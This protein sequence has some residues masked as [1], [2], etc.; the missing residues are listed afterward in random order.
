MV[1]AFQLFSTGHTT[2]LTEYYGRSDLGLH[3]KNL[4]RTAAFPAEALGVAGVWPHLGLRSKLPPSWSS[5]VLPGLSIV[6]CAA[7]VAGLIGMRA[8]SRRRGETDELV[9]RYLW[10]TVLLVSVLTVGTLSLLSL[11]VPLQTM[12]GHRDGHWTY[13]EELRYYAPISLFMFLSIPWLVQRRNSLVRRALATAG[14]LAM[15]FASSIAAREH[16]RNYSQRVPEFRPT[17]KA[18]FREERATVMRLLRERSGAR[19][20]VYLD[21]DDQL[22][23]AA[24][25]VGSPTFLGDASH[26]APVATET[27]TAVVGVPRTEVD[28][29]QWRKFLSTSQATPVAETRSRRFYEFEIHA[30]RVEYSFK[31]TDS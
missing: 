6:V 5:L 4:S 8:A 28:S 19:R 13:V 24:D 30:E 3:W 11:M 29:D 2:F 12:D 7:S 21:S 27:V 26:L 9:Y 10:T 20:A 16:I 31:R 22:T 1:C 17:E 25:L 14:V 15:L 23:L 18:E